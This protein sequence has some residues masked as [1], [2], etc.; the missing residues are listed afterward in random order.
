MLKKRWT[1]VL[2][3][4][5]CLAPIG[6]LGWRYWHDDLTSNP[7]EY[8]THFTGDWTIRLIVTTLAI[9]PLRKL[10]KLP[11]LIRFRRLIGLFAF[12]YGTLHFLTWFVLDK[13]FDMREI[14]ADVTKRPYI[15]AG[16]TAFVCMLPLAV[17][18]TTGWIRRMGGKRWQMLHR[19]V[20]LSGI[21]GVVHYY[22]LVKS[23]IRLPLLYGSLVGILLAYR[24]IVWLLNW[25][26][27]TAAK[28]PVAMAQ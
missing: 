20:Y 22:W 12:F 6:W 27:G 7:I 9:T 25:R 4:L 16:F 15:M 2:F 23:D 24:L 18:S 28:R 11:D 19:L 3:W 17:T 10:L 13:F 5:A 21:A 14:L 1:K 8:I 26:P